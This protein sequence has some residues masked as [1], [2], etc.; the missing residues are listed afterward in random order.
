MNINH[1]RDLVRMAN[2]YYDKVTEV[3]DKASPGCS[4]A[5]RS[6][7]YSV[8]DELL[9][10]FTSVRHAAAAVGFCPKHFPKYMKDIP[11]FISE[12]VTYL[13]PAI[14][15]DFKI[16]LPNLCCSYIFGSKQSDSVKSKVNCL[17]KIIQTIVLM[18]RITIGIFYE[19]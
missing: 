11:E 14:F 3:A 5:V 6:T 4:E 2:A 1:T 16:T 9:A 7:L 13:V 15:A 12:T 10:N 17:L 19:K 8:R 18:Y